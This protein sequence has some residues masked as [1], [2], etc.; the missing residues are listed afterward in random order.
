VS[1][2]NSNTHY[3]LIIYTSFRL[4]V[5]ASFIE[6]YVVEFQKRGLPHAHIPLT[7]AT[8][9]N[10]AFLEYVDRLISAE[11]LDQTIDPL[12]YEAITKIMIH[13]PCVSHLIDGKCSKYYLKRFCDQT[14]FVEYNFAIYRQQRNL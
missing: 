6:V 11:I 10:P 1:L 14:K 7:V 5:I 2:L 8:E 9:D 4:L 12:T 3:L 13:G